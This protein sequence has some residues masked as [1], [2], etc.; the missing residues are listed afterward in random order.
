VLRL[1]LDETDMHVH[2]VCVLNKNWFAGRVPFRRPAELFGTDDNA[3]L[4]FYCSILKGQQ[5]FS[6]HQ[7]DLD[8]YLPDAEKH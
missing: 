8:A 3:L 7:M 6:V 1:C 4:S 5:N 2:G